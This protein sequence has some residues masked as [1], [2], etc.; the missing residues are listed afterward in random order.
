ML[1]LD[2]EEDQ[3]AESAGTAR[4]ESCVLTPDD[5]NAHLLII[6]LEH[7]AARHRTGWRTYILSERSPSEKSRHRGPHQIAD[8]AWR[9]I[10]L[11]ERVFPDCRVSNYHFSQDSRAELTLLVLFHPRMSLD[12]VLLDLKTTVTLHPEGR[13]SNLNSHLRGPDAL[14]DRAVGLAARGVGFALEGLF[15]VDL[16]PGFRGTFRGT[17]VLLLVL[18]VRRHCDS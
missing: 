7:R 12:A 9:D 1:R 13:L 2:E 16:G 4:W 14:D 17:R 8:R 18:I 11:F 15:V 3:S 10:L 5:A 6:M